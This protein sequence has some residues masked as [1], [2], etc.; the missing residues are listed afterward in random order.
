MGE[1]PPKEVT[2]SPAHASERPEPRPEGY[3]APTAGEETTICSEG[4]P[5]ASQ[6][7]TGISSDPIHRGGEEGI[8]FAP[9]SLVGPYRVEAPIGAGGMGVVFKAR[10][11]RLNR[12]VALK[13]IHP[14]SS[15]QQLQ[16]AFLREARLASSLN[17]PGI[18]TIYDILF[19]RG[20]TC[21]VMEYVSGS[22]LHH[23]IPPGGL[24][25]DRALAIGC[26]IGN[27]VAAAHAAGVVH[28]DLKPANV[29]V[30]SDDSIKILDF[31][32]AKM[33]ATA[34]PDADT[35]PL[36]IFHGSA[37]GTVGYMPPEQA[38]GAQ[39][40]TRA[41]I[42]S[43]GVILYRM[44][45][46]AMPFSGPSSVD[47]LHAIHRKDPPSMRSIRPEIP[48]SL[49]KAVRRALAPNAAD[50]F[51]TI[52]ELLEQL[53][54]ESARPSAASRQPPASP[55][56]SERSIVVLPFTNSSPEPEN[57]YLCDG[58]AEELIDGLTRIG[59]LRV[60]SRSS[61]FQF[62]GT[63][64][65]VREIGQRLGVR[66]V[67]NG[68]LRRSAAN[69]RLA[70]QLTQ[71]SDGFQV[72]SKR[73]DAKA[74]DLFALQDELTSAVLEEL[75]QQLGARFSALHT[76]H[77]SPAP[78]S[79]DLFLRARYAFNRETPMGFQEARDLFRS[80]AAADPS[81]APA[82]I[83]IAETHM[84]LE[85]Y[86]LEPASEAAPAAKSALDAALRLRPDSATGLCNLAITQAGWDW[87]WAA[88]GETFQRALHAG[89]DLAMV[90]FHYGLDFLTPHG[91]LQEALEEMRLA[92][93][94][95]PLSAIVD[96]AIG[97]SLYRMQRY[98]E[99]AKTL[100][101]TLET[102]PG[103]GHAHWSLGRVR[104]EQGLWDEAVRHF[105]L[106][107]E[108][109]GHPPAA[110][111]ESAYCHAR[112][113]SRDVAQAAIRELQRRSENEPVS[114]LNEALVYAGLG[115]DDAAME[116]LELAFRRRM[117]QLIW[118]NVDPR[119]APLRNNP[120][121]RDLI[122]RMGLPPL[123]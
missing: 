87:D 79:Y 25:I 26:A 49:E 117:R 77:D 33:M 92:G 109:M 53:S 75:R 70:V 19:I 106:A 43:F 40:D 14:T 69:I 21:I 1:I 12:D 86:G 118:V 44:L 13:I 16:A 60:V 35:E 110:L 7:S 72:W 98:A 8:S 97:G 20:L 54:Q 34:S 29:L 61:S 115:E 94:L 90:H 4:H 47:V 9:G 80:A 68:S 39:A 11:T 30:R 114:P 57:E 100:E 66:L 101:A 62:K 107:A 56:Y 6:E 36:S 71:T 50:R 55:Q 45:T 15:N 41:D 73:F 52:G 113:G 103:F 24:S 10:D 83:G 112:M 78:E 84:R 82:W 74:Q 42:F 59:G 67:V 46:G 95:E 32:L 120:G 22:P 122:S 64:P 51:Q 23:L 76:M 88:A 119:F 91:R 31:G 99:A 96:T 89:S 105:T 48:Q 116:R 93:Q 102:A 17:H 37:V 58:L 63:N 2:T 18:V 121:F 5:L 85:W 111:A 38:G 81:F 104:V 27:A 3:S 65:D 28:R 108:I 123:L